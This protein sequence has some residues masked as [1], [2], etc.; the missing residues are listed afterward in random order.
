MSKESTVKRWKLIIEY[1][2]TNYAGFQIQPGLPTIQGSIQ[3]AIKEFSGQEVSLTVAGRT[4]AGVHA[5]HQ[6]AHF[7]FDYQYKDGRSREITPYELAKAINSF[8]VDEPISIL[9]AEIVSHDFHARFGAKHKIYHYVIT[10]RRFKTG[11]DKGRSW[12]VKAPLDLDSMIE[13]SKILIGKHD[14]TSFRDTEC[15]AKSPI[16]TIDKIDFTREEILNGQKIIMTIE[17][18]S[19]LHHM[20]RNIIGTLSLVGEGKW[21]IEDVQKALDAKNR[22]AAGPTAPS[23]GLYLVKIDYD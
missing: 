23:D 16:R 14:F 4:D 2:G 12:W 13:A 5:Y 6:V 8:L 3:R 18:R 19:F 17:G 11:L 15:Q 10:N 22:T 9:D 7:D 1:N 20:V 21:D